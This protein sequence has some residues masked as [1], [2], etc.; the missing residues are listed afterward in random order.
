MMTLG[1]CDMETD[2]ISRRRHEVIG[3]I[4]PPDFTPNCTV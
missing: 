4:D 2:I 1:S 3:V